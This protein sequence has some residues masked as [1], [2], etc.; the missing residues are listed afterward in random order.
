MKISSLHL[1]TC[2]SSVIFS[3]EVSFE[4]IAVSKDILKICMETPHSKLMSV[5]L[6][7]YHIALNLL[8]LSNSK[9]TFYAFG[10]C[11]ICSEA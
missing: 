7:L 6:V 10:R 4:I 11:K 5:L 3:A 2:G 1:R 8:T 9:C